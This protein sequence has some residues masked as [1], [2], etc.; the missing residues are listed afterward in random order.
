MNILYI[1]PRK[2]LY[3]L[4]VC[5][6]CGHVWECENCSSNLITYRSSY[7]VFDM[8]CHHCQTSYTYPNQC[9][10][11]QSEDISSAVGGID[12]LVEQLEN[13]FNTKVNR[14]DKKVANLPS[15]FEESIHSEPASILQDTSTDH[16]I[17]F[18]TKLDFDENPNIFVSTRVFDPAI[19]Y[20]HFDVII[21]YQAHNLIASPDYMAHEE[22]YI[23]LTQLFGAVHNNSEIV[24]QSHKDIA[25]LNDILRL[26][27]THEHY[28][29]LHQWYYE[30][31][32]EELEFRK[33]YKFPP[34]ANL[35][36]LTIHEKKESAAQLKAQTLKQILDTQFGKEAEL[37]IS[38]P[39]QPKLLKRKGYYS[40]H[41]L[42]K[43]P[44]KW[45]K[46]PELRRY[47]QEIQQQ[48][49]IQVRLNPRH[50]F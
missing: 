17:T 39:Y 13:E 2:G 15:I 45:T 36:L 10:T 47:I 49:R 9:P 19:H 41:V 44:R 48:Y 42:L 4:T 37:S 29:G 35:I 5:N 38:S 32:N 8:L 46:Y 33:E 27:H 12:D 30:H 50:V 43:Y 28:I 20:H 24:L 23:S 11:C 16:S 40:Y 34:F 14:L 18:R 22:M 1:H 26:N 7:D 25:I 6:A 31:L 21:L 3:R